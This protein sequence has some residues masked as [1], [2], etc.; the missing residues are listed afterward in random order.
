M[1]MVFNC[2][3]CG[4]VLSLPDE[5][6]GFTGQCALCGA[7]IVAPS[8]EQPARLVTGPALPPNATGG[9]PSTG[10]L[11]LG[12]LITEAWQ[13]MM[14]DVGQYAVATLVMILAPAA[15]IFPL[16]FLVLVPAVANPKH[17]P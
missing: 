10:A 6:A 15:V 9:V 2:P 14:R 3:Y 11:D 17:P 12:A 13:V 7:M 4:R 5:S 1:A 16:E 8:G